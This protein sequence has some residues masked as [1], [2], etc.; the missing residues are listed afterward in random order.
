MHK[1]RIC[2]FTTLLLLLMGGCMKAPINGDLDGQW[3]VMSVTPVPANI[4]INERLFYNFSLQVCD[5]TYYGALFT[6]GNINYTGETLWIDFPLVK[7]EKGVETLK[8]YGVLT[9]P[10]CFNVEFKDKHHLTLY[11]EDSVVELVKH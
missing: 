6:H 9:N 3:E 5:L 10:V 1:I 4:V 2:L 11:N 7:S 8:Q